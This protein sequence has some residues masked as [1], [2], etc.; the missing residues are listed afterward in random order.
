M[1]W[2]KPEIIDN[3]PTKYGWT[4]SHSDR[5]ELGYMTDIGRGT[6]LQC[7]HG[8]IIQ[9]NVQIGGNCNIYSADTIGGNAGMVT[10]KEGAC[11]GTQSIIMPG[12]TIGMGAIVMANSFVPAN[13]NIPDGESWGGTPAEPSHNIY[14]VTGGTGSIGRSVVERLL[15]DD[16]VNAVRVYSRDEAKQAQMRAELDDSRLRYILGDVRDKD[17]L[18]RAFEGASTV[19]HAAALKRVESCQY[20]PDECK[21]VNIDGSEKVAQ[22]AF[23]NKVKKVLLISTDKAVN[24]TNAMGTSKAMA[25][26]MYQGYNSWSKRPQFWIAR[27][28]N[29]LESRGSV[30][31]TWRQQALANQEIIVTDRNAT[32]YFIENKDVATFILDCLDRPAGLYVPDC[33]VMKIGDLADAFVDSCTGTYP[34]GI[35]ETEMRPGERMNEAML[36][37]EEAL[38][39]GLEP[40]QYQ[41]EK[42]IPLTF[43]QIKELL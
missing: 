20:C 19:I 17:A 37:S 11:I 5:L 9:D 31:P 30:L 39:R 32:R 22:A 42:A 25:E 7:Q 6:Y 13:T 36:T 14:V 8:I 41:S 4:V 24:P 18:R 35:K 3:V 27:L 28:G 38:E 26:K 2:T 15:L 21:S 33:K 23:Y 12:C 34:I 43:S 16:T 40:E 10:I 29:V 1:T